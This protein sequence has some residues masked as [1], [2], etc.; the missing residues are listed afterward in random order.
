MP[1]GCILQ[2][3]YHSA[4]STAAQTT[5]YGSVSSNMGWSCQPK[6]HARMPLLYIS[7][8]MLCN[9]NQFMMFIYFSQNAW[10][11]FVVSHCLDL[12]MFWCIWNEKLIL[13]I[14]WHIWIPYQTNWSLHICVFVHELVSIQFSFWNKNNTDL[15]DLLFLLIPLLWYACSLHSKPFNMKKI[16]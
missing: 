5:I 14:Q 12:G 4:R 7:P 11:I 15:C 1:C 8:C 9:L 13:D 10:I 2:V 6:I 3:T 16:E